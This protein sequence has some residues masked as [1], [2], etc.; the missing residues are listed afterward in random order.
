MA[1]FLPNFSVNP[2]PNTCR[3]QKQ[4]E[5]SAGLQRYWLAFFFLQNAGVIFTRVFCSMTAA[6]KLCHRR[7]MSALH[8]KD[9]L[10]HTQISTE[11][12]FRAS[13]RNAV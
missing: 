13:A 8:T 5:Y 7:R 12:V 9:H 3:H 1:S 4:K 10:K 6:V 11:M 2:C